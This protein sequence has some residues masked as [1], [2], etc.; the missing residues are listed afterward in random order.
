MVVFLPTQVSVEFH[1]KVFVNSLSNPE[2]EKEANHDISIF[3]LH[4]EM[5]QK[6]CLS[7]MISETY[8]HSDFLIQWNPF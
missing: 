5:Q 2:D 3:K 4:G 1:Y 8:M 6:V 7:L